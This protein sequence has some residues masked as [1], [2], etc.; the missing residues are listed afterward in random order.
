MSKILVTGGAGYIGSH[1]VYLLSKRGYDVVVVDDLSRGHAE[2]VQGKPVHQISLGNT[3]ALIRLMRDE[4]FDAVVH[5]AAYIAV[6]ESTKKP[7]LYFSNNVGGSISLLDA[8]AQTG[9]KRLVFSST[10]AV[11]GDPES[12]PIRED[13][14]IN[15]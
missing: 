12:V 9:I 8:M 6:G 10:A 14:P 5:F 11:Y 1:T 4:S 13:A 15:P 7:E 3:A 2:N